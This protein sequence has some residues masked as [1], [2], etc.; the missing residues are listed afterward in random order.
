M[1]ADQLFALAAD[2]NV[3]LHDRG[4]M[5]DAQ[6]DEMGNVEFGGDLD[7]LAC[8]DEVDRTEELSLCCGGARYTD[9]M[10]EGVSRRDQVAVGIGVDRIAGYDFATAAQFGFRTGANQGPYAVAALQEDGNQLAA[11]VPSAAGDENPARVRRPGKHLHLEH[12][13]NVGNG[14][15]HGKQMLRFGR[16]APT[17]SRQET[18]AMGTQ[19]SP[20]RS[21]IQ[22][23]Q[24]GVIQTVRH[25]NFPAGPCARHRPL[26]SGRADAEFSDWQRRL[27]TACNSDRTP[28]PPEH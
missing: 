9:Q 27:W 1:F 23:L 15:S 21:L 14:C 25:E 26:E 7:G 5:G 2:L 10:D 19:T 18:G 20:T 16:Q 11:H 6:V 12:L 17:P 3:S 4:R 28:G 8:G 13:P 22:L 24:L